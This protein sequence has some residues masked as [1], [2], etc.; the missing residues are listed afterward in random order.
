MR[1]PF[2]KGTQHSVG[3]V[4]VLGNTAQ[5]ITVNCIYCLLEKFSYFD[6]DS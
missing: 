2:G 6:Q 5:I 4:D 1:Y 3:K